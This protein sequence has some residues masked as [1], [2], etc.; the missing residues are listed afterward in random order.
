M[1]RAAVVVVLALFLAGCGSS[2]GNEKASEQPPAPATSTSGCSPLPG[3]TSN[4]HAADGPSDTMF[5]T[6]VSVEALECTDRITFGFRDAVA[7]PGYNI[8]YE[9]GSAAKTED[10][11]GRTIEVAG[12]AFLV[13][14]LLSTA[15]AEI[16][17]EELTPTYTGPRRIEE[18][19]VHFVREVVKTGDFENMV[20]W[21]I[22]LDG[23]RP[24]KLTASDSQLIVDIG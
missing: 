16:S 14:R 11:S 1:A 24:Y 19:G 17:G 13:V 9:P 10:G 8:S 12:S 2:T 21:A 22:G 4:A 15:T 23:R 3:A 20:T 5:L 7:Q 6:S 18:P